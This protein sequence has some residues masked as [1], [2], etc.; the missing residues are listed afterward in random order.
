MAT[1]SKS[2]SEVRG[3]TMRT[4]RTISKEL[5]SGST[6][7]DDEELESGSTS[8]DDEE[9]HVLNMKEIFI[10]DNEAKESLLKI[11]G[12]VIQ[13][14]NELPKELLT[15]LSRLYGDVSSKLK[16]NA[17]LVSEKCKLV[18]AGESNSDMNSVINTVLGSEILPNPHVLSPGTICCVHT[19]PSNVEGYFVIQ[20]TNGSSERHSYPKV[21]GA[22]QGLLSDK[23]KG[24]MSQRI[25]TYCHLPVFGNT[26]SVKIVSHLGGDNLLPTEFMKSVDDA[27]ILIYVVNSA[28][29]DGIQEKKLMQM[30]KQ[31][32]SDARVDNLN[33]FDPKCM[34]MFV[35]NNWDIVEEKE[36]SDPGAES[37]I[38]KEIVTK[39][40]K[41]FP[42][43]SEH[44]QIYKLGT[45]EAMLL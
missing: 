28:C 14:V 25:E 4:E 3:D 27:S 36:R 22:F 34:M 37:R 42:G 17:T 29:S 24:K 21:P 12:Q 20:M 43:I 32:Q 16:M 33:S 9:E 15:L 41:Y 19:V 11:Y 30:C 35:C 40:Q 2:L 5:E 6:S 10:T 8:V 31:L 45:T 26:D 39:I 13:M 44:D 7:V 23:M 1:S 18:V 38:W